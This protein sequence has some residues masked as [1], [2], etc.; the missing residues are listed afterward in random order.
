MKHCE[1]PRLRRKI[2]RNPLCSKVL[3]ANK[4]VYLVGGYLRDL[5]IRGV[6]S[7]DIDF[8][9]RKNVRSIVN[10]VSATFG[11]RV[12][13]LRKE[14]MLRVILAGGTT[15]DFSR[16]KGDIEE[17]LGGRD[18]TINAMAWSPATGLIDPNC[19]LRDIEKGVISAISGQNLKDDPLRLLRAYRFAAELEMT[20]SKA[21][22]GLI[23]PLAGK[24]RKSATERITLEFFK[25]LNSENPSKALAEALSDGVLMHI[26]PLSVNRLRNNIKS[27][28]SLDN[29]VKK[30]HERHILKEFSQGLSMRGLLR[31]ER[32]MLGAE[33][34]KALFSL[35]ADI[36]KR[37]RDT[38]RFYGE[39]KKI[40]KV[41]KYKVFELFSAAG[42]SA[43][44]L[45][46]LTGHTALLADL[47]RF[48]R[49]QTRGLIGAEEIMTITG[50][51]SGPRLG[52][53]IR[54]MKRLQFAGELSTRQAARRWLSSR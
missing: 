32:L 29:I 37:L 18:F 20:V 19:G 6:H 2:L 14:R 51:G 23:R 54:E 4:D 26:I 48:E 28:S 15:V 44:D 9:A 30:T 45:L 17:D 1:V 33:P 39:Y 35:S 22:R 47:K 10:Y 40:N 34:D 5:I 13:E 8:V 25:L 41:N 24:I 27:I 46:L 49:I 52:R 3:S 7:K 16:M 42:E 53:V 38:D 43:G 50:L 31:L 12:V 21:T 11:G 36:R